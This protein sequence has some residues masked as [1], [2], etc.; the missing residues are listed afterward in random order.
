MKNLLGRK[1]GRLEVTALTSR[2][3]SQG[4]RIWLC[5]CECGA[6]TEVRTNHLTRGSTKSCGCYARDLADAARKPKPPRRQRVTLTLTQEDRR[7][8]AV[9][10]A[11]RQRCNNPAYRDYPRYGGRGIKVCD[12]WASFG[13]FLADMGERQP[14]LTLERKDNNGDYE[15]SNCRWATMKEQGRNR[16]NSRWIM[17]EGRN[18]CLAEWCDVFGVQYNR[19]YRQIT[20]DGELPTLERLLFENPD[21]MT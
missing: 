1:F 5:R 19:T 9:W 20:R 13:N 15:L 12:R 11:M 8:R 14:G 18:L 16:R 3:S 10:G 21:A 6:V 17:F 7:L 4:E 2:R